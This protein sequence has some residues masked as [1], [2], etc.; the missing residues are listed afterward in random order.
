MCTIMSRGGAKSWWGIDLP[1]GVHHLIK[2]IGDDKWKPVTYKE[3]NAMRVAKMNAHLYEKRAHE[4]V[5]PCA[6]WAFWNEPLWHMFFGGWWIY[7][8]TL[9][10]DVPL[11][12]RGVRKDLIMQV[13]A[14]FPCGCLPF[15]ETYDEIWFNAFEKQYHYPGKREKNSIAFAHCRLDGRGRILEIVK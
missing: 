10:G 2:D 15:D 4:E 12:F 13:K 14:L 1:Q 8:R 5:R 7:V 3:I 9:K 6:V 11:N